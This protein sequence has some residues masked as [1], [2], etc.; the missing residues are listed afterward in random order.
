MFFCDIEVVETTLVKLKGPNAKPKSIPLAPV[1]N[2]M[3]CTLVPII[4][5]YEKLDTTYLLEGLQHTIESYPDFAGELHYDARG[6]WTSECTNKGVRFIR[7]KTTATLLEP[8]RNVSNEEDVPNAGVIPINIAGVEQEDPKDPETR[9]LTVQVTEFADGAVSVGVLIHHKVTDAT[10]VFLFFCNWSRACNMLA[11]GVPIQEIPPALC[12]HD[13]SL[14]APRYKVPKFPHPEYA[15]RAPAK[16]EGIPPPA[17]FDECLAKMFPFPRE[18]LENLKVA[19]SDPAK[20]FKATS[21]DVIVAL[22]VKSVTKAR[23][24]PRNTVVPIGWSADARKR[25]PYLPIE[26]CGNAGFTVALFPTAGEIEDMSFQEMAELISKTTKTRNQEYIEDTLVWM[27]SQEDLTYLSTDL[28][29]LNVGIAFSN[30][31][32]PDPRLVDFGQGKAPFYFGFPPVAF[33][34]L[35]HVFPDNNGGRKALL[36]LRTE[37]MLRLAED[38]VFRKYCPPTPLII[39][40]DPAKARL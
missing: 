23:Q 22:I 13:K 16:G 10:T 39:R 6:R 40:S 11:K 7:A 19:F 5:I 20:G 32:T 17:R 18:V 29:A 21:N 34:G 4:M 3:I 15:A 37:Q 27:D 35:C 1:D 33:D 30:T 8:L 12:C 2:C 28:P 14:L 36:G 26:Y 38:P 31:G 25:L 24:L 9:P